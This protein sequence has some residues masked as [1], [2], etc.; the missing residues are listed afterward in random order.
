MSVGSALTLE[1]SIRIE[2]EVETEEKHN[3]HF[4]IKCTKVGSEI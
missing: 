1:I 2:S 4:N 3:I